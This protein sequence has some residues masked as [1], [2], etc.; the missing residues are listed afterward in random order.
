VKTYAADKARHLILRA[1][2]GESLPGDLARALADEAVTCGW[3][4]ASGV[5]RDVELRA[6]DGAL[7]APAP[8]RRIAGTVHALSIEGSVALEGSEPTVGL[9]AVL[10]READ[11]GMEVLAGEI[12]A[13]RVVALE[14]FVTAFDDLPLT[15]A[16][17]PAAGVTLFAGAAGAVEAAR[18]QPRPALGWSEAI[19]ASDR[20]AAA[21]APAAV[22]APS[23]SAPSPLQ[24]ALDRAVPNR[25]A[26]GGA[27]PARPARPASSYDETLVP[28]DGDTVEHFAFGVM[29]V[30]KSEGDRLHLRAGTEGRIREISLEMLRVTPLPSDGPNRR[31]KLDRK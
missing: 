15:R 31:F 9:R 17:D 18:A 12:V 16:L 6:F 28:Q 14:A 25:G 3:L 13:A 7:G 11:R 30:I 21:P 29:N 2:A 19:A 4:R 27:I 1:T 8:A 5:L 23:P 26:L 10:A 22:P 20:P 24:S